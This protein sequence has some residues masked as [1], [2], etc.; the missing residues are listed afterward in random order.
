MIADASTWPDL[1]APAWSET[2][3]TLHMWLQIV[4]KVRLA[5]EPMV[6]HWWQVPL[7]VTGVGLTTSLMPTG[8]GGLEI[9]FDFQRHA[10][11]LR[12]VGG[13]SREITLRP[14]SVADFYAELFEGLS[15][16]GVDVAIYPVPVEVP[17]AIPFAEDTDHASYDPEYVQRFWHALVSINA[18]LK[19][20][21]AGFI[22]KASPVHFFWGSFDL[23]A[24]RF[25]GRTAPLHP[26]GAPNCPSRV[27][28][29]AYS[30]EVSSCGYWPGGGED[31]LFYSY[32]YPEPAGLRDR[33]VGPPGASF[34]HDLG[35]FVLPYGTVRAARDPRSALA[36]FLQTTY[37]AAA[38]L[39]EWDRSALEMPRADRAT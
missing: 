4:G 28:E 26:G 10:L 36:E 7:Y 38:D 5:L 16:I 23:A 3:D 21:R 22:G 30:H 2:R 31:G 39:L 24:T 33:P 27:M 11:E 1:P 18:V 19:E 13:G 37:E 20:F 6:N 9:S 25:S 12:T 34:D 17:V 29:L 35:E 14:L 32:A 8:A 15:S